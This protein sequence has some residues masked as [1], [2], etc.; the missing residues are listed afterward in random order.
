MRWLW[1]RQIRTAR[2]ILNA[3]IKTYGKSLDD[4]SLNTLL[5]E[6]APII[7]FRPMKTETISDVE[8][9]I[10]LSPA[11]LLTMKSKVILPPPGCFP[12]ADIYS[13][14]RWKR[15]QHIAN[16]FW[17]RWRKEFLL[18]L[19]KRK[20]CK[21]RRRNF[22]NG[23]MVLLKAETHRN[24]WPVAC[25]IETSKDKHGVV[26]TVKLKPGSENNAQRELVQPTTKILLLVEGDSPTESQCLNQN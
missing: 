11:H 9:D 6:V 4:E 26:Q 10:P 18:T 1:E 22:R 15:V 13:R 17:S 20:S 24:H 25:I 2:H 21:T 14:K 12:W 3:L 16:K 8:S 7:N 23:D 19:Q 5:V